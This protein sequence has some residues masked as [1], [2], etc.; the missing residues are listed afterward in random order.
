LH[1]HAVPI[2]ICASTRRFLHIFNNAVL[3]HFTHRCLF[4][5]A[6]NASVGGADTVVS[7][8]I[9]LSVIP[10]VVLPSTEGGFGA[11]GIISNWS[12]AGHCQRF[13]F[14]CAVFSAIAPGVAGVTTLAT[15]S[16]C[17]DCG[18]MVTL[19]FTFM[20]LGYYPVTQVYV[21]SNG[22]INIDKNVS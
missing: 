1:T 17:D 5:F 15:V 8:L 6:G 2:F 19:P 22:Y 16:A 7:G 11:T 12:V 4:C 10:P 21:N 14:D 9:D 13:E 20:W 3:T 18:Q